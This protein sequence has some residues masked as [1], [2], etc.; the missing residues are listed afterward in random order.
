VKESSTAA[1]SWL[2]AIQ[3]RHFPAP[4]LPF[5][6]GRS[7]FHDKK[8]TVSRVVPVSSW[9]RRGRVGPSRREREERVRLGET[10]SP[11]PCAL[12][13]R[14][15]RR[16]RSRV[17]RWPSPQSGSN[18]TKDSSIRARQGCR[19]GRSL[20]SRV[21]LDARLA[22]SARPQ[23][24]CRRAGVQAWIHQS[25][26]PYP[27][28]RVTPP[29]LRRLS[30]PTSVLIPPPSS[31][32]HPPDTSIRCAFSKTRLQCL[33]RKTLL[34]SPGL[35]TVTLLLCASI[36]TSGRLRSPSPPLSSVVG[37]A[38]QHSSLDT[39]T[40][41]I[42]TMAEFAYASFFPYTFPPSPAR[43]PD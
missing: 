5:F 16:E 43:T 10:K 40:R 27:H 13:H 14:G 18:G 4:G 41:P 6:L 2:L 15:R 32:H 23:S 36:P 20:G 25:H 26:Y 42:H 3:G 31:R 11:S 9:G 1:L 17:A 19:S 34:S 22:A 29:S 12:P 33:R 30:L 7:G 28:A 35:A 37:C 38:P 8:V 24:R 39:Y 21:A